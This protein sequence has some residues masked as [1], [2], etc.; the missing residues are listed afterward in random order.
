MGATSLRTTG[1]KYV[2]TRRPAVNSA[3]RAN[4]YMTR[5]AHDFLRAHEESFKSR[6][7]LAS[8][9]SDFR[10]Q[11]QTN[12]DGYTA[13]ASAWIRALSAAANQ[14]LLPS[15]AGATQHDHFLLS[16]G[17]A[18]AQAL[19]T[20]EHGR[21]LALGSVIEE[22][23]RK[24]ELVPMQE[25]LDGKG[26]IYAKSW[27]PTPWQVL[28][29]G[30]RQLGVLA[31]GNGAEDKLVRGDFVIMANVEAAAKNVLRQVDRTAV[32]N[33]GRI[34]SAELFNQIATEAVGADALSA[35]DSSVLLVHLAR[36]HASLR[37]DAKTGTIKFKAPDDTVPPPV[38]QE[39]ITIASLRTLITSLEPQIKQLMAKASEL[40][41][42]AREAVV[43]KQ[44][45]AAKTAL[46]QKKMAETKLGQR[47]AT[48][49]QLEDVYAKIEQAADQV[50]IVRVMEASSQ[51][52]KSLHRK[53]GGVEK[54]QDVMESL[55]DE[56]MNVDEIGHAIND[57]G[58]EGVDEGYV[59]EEFDALEKAEREKIEQAERLERE[60]KEA[61]EAEET[62]KRLAELDQPAK[63]TEKEAVS[64]AEESEKTKQAE[65][66][67]E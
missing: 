33:T 10:T 30:L 34:F 32:G 23:V 67:Q 42:K 63:E 47:T 1:W 65:A 49:A 22:A 9:Y 14:G 17:E 48:L 2:P 56:M 12:P 57:V 45:L 35:K 53:T 40:D 21:P 5:Q 52:L 4:E 51:T 19:T 64:V 11:R 55:K 61:I 15:Q 8:L 25:F 60:R 39:D 46:R 20:A 54:V 37:Y 7:R 3:E 38:E 66:V 16:S 13:N 18:L 44:N 29:W 24:N 31:D 36:D 50:D 28:S 62:R 43:A 41:A 27:V 6:A 58:A 26:S 59:D